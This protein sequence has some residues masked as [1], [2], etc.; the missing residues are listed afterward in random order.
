MTPRTLLI[1]LLAIGIV[2]GCAS[3]V[4]DKTLPEATAT[5]NV[6][7]V[8]P[9]PGET[10]TAD[11]VFSADVTY[12]IENY[13]RGADYY[14]APLFG[15]TKGEGST[16]N[17][18]DRISDAPHLAAAAGSVAFK[19]PFRR[20]LRSNNLG[21]PVKIWLFVM[22]RTGAHTTRVIGQAGPY[23]YATADQP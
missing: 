7:N 5:V 23:E 21:R 2:S 11:T 20:E 4:V 13:Q 19:Y 6:S 12:S 9:A 3:G 22:E 1:A 8:T 17:E 18:L 15:S 14:L 16:F 10:I